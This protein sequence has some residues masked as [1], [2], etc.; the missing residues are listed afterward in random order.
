MAT[1]RHGAGSSPR[2]RGKPKAPKTVK[3]TVRLI[4]ARAGKTPLTRWVRVSL[5][6]HPRAGGENRTVLIRNW[7]CRGSSPRGRGKHPRR[8]RCRPRDR[9]IPARAGKT[10]AQPWPPS[11][12]WAHPRAGGENPRSRGGANR[13]EGSSPRGR[14]KPETRARIQLYRR[15]IP[16]RAGKTR[17]S[18]RRGRHCRAHPRAGGENLKFLVSATTDTGSSPRGRG[19]PHMPR[20]SSRALRL[21]PARAGKT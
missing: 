15:L 19:K 17:P 1:H 5:R 4:P 20:P 7:R 21:I 18:R 6:P 12:P 3:L 11:H 10:Y 9:L 16:A 14:G 8:P 13:H 2:G